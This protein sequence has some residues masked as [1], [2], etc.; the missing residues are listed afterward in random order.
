MKI[1]TICVTIFLASCLLLPLAFAHSPNHRFFLE[2]DGTLKLK[3]A[4]SGL[5]STIRYRNPDGSYP[6]S[7]IQKI[8]KSLAYRPVHP[9]GC[10]FAS[11]HFWII[12]E[13]H[14]KS[15]L[16]EI[17]SGYRSPEYNAQDPQTRGT[18]R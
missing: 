7:A 16:I 6:D 3:N 17:V 11:S 14:F 8:I 1:K 12:W 15:P 18:R 4:K 13:D 10:H 2:G 5:T 9:K